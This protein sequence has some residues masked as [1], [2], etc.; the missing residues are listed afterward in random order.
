MAGDD[1]HLDVG[2]LLQLV[3]QLDPLAVRKL[4]VDDGQVEAARDHRLARLGERA[5]GAHL[6]ALAADPLGQGLPA[7]LVVVDEQCL[8]HVP[9]PSVGPREVSRKR[10]RPSCVYKGLGPR[11][12]ED[13]AMRAGT[14][15]ELLAAVALLLAAA[16][17]AASAASSTLE[18]VIAKHVE[19][20]GG[21]E[22]WKAIESLEIK[23]SMTQLSQTGPFTLWLGRNDRYLL[24]SQQHGQTLTLGYDGTTAW[25]GNRGDPGAAQ[26][27]GGVERAMI[28]RDADFPTPF[29]DYKA[30]G[31]ELRHLG[32][33][34]LDGEPALAIEV[35]RPDGY[36]ETWYLDPATFLDIARDSPGSYFG[37]VVPMRT[38]H[39]DFRTVAGVKMPFRIESQWHVQERVLSVDSIEVDVAI[40]QARFSP[41][42]PA[43]MD[44]L[45][46]LA[47]E[48]RVVAS[49]SQHPGAPWRDSER[50]STIEKLLGGALLEERYTTATGQEVVRSYT[51]D[52][53]RQEYRITE[54]SDA[55]NY[56]DVQEGTFDGQG[57]LVV[58]NVE[59][60][61]QVEGQGQKVHVRLTLADISESGFRVEK[62]ISTDGGASWTLAAKS[63]Y[64]RVKKA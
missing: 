6:E 45:L 52:R 28:V 53:F 21:A 32:Q 41:P 64:T 54:I 4:Q 19:A 43:G 58:S 31:Y 13:G 11:A 20:R 62:E 3:D 57:R 1:Q 9:Q 8:G 26:R 29:F 24:E 50:T 56:L 16:A 22:R 59:T 51:Y 2:L 63:S 15:R 33:R 5:G 35:K 23:G 25:R 12:Q 47:G 30:R 7:V 48:W 44:P 61:T 18:Q 42:R 37:E 49:T 27:I 17:S 40:D 38:F 36:A 60:G 55:S 34:D 10:C 14:R 46:P 39:D